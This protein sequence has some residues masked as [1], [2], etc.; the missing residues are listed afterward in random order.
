MKCNELCKSALIPKIDYVETI[1]GNL[2][3]L[4]IY[5]L[6]SLYLIKHFQVSFS[7]YV[8]FITNISD[9]QGWSECKW[10][11]A[12]F[13][14]ILLL[15]TVFSQMNTPCA[16][17]TKIDRECTLIEPMVLNMPAFKARFY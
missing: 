10:Q 7:F 9:Y 11:S 6:N 4:T 2:S 3:N 5:P 15:H 13:F 17:E 12:D 14:M 8:I 1:H 16:S